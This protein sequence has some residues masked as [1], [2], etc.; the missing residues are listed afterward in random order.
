MVVNLH[1]E[2]QTQRWVAEGAV[3]SHQL[4]APESWW[5]AC[6]TSCPSC[7]AHDGP[8][9]S[10]CSSHPQGKGQMLQAYTLP[11]HQGLLIVPSALPVVQQLSLMREALTEYPEPPAH[12]NHDREYGPLVGVWRAA[13]QGMVLRVPRIHEERTAPP[14][15]IGR[16]G[17]QAHTSQAPAPGSTHEFGECMTEAAASGIQEAAVQVERAAE[18]APSRHSDSG[19]SCSSETSCGSHDL[20]QGVGSHAEKTHRPLGAADERAAAPKMR[21]FEECWAPAPA[22]P[23]K[24]A[25]GGV[26]AGDQAGGGACLGPPAA[27]MLRRLRWATLG[28]Q[29]DWTARVYDVEGLHRCEPAEAAKP[30][31]HSLCDRL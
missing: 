10:S 13:Q 22:K 1:D 30:V 14:G 31:S 23:G 25:K 27:T 18:A 16:K 12:T 20:L 19:A 4:P 17:C 5:S 26:T 9:E 2:A 11:A 21:S 7:S 15:V 28:P 29:F 6:Q 24:G 3:R 8:G